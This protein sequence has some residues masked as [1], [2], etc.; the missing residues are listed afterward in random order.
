MGKFSNQPNWYDWN[1]TGETI[2]EEELNA[3]FDRLGINK[4]IPLKSND[5]PQTMASKYGCDCVCVKN[6]PHCQV[7]YFVEQIKNHLKIKGKTYQTIKYKQRCFRVSANNMDATDSKKASDVYKIFINL[8]KRRFNIHFNNAFK[9]I[10]DRQK[11]YEFKRCIPAPINY[12]RVDVNMYTNVYKIDISSAYAYEFSKD[13]PTAE[14]MIEVPGFVKPTSDF[15]FAYYPK[16][17]KLEIYG[18]NIKS[19][20]IAAERTVLM[21]KSNYSLKPLLEE[22]YEKKELAKDKEERQSYKNL[23]N[24]TVGYLQRNNNPT[25]AYITAVVIARCDER[26][27]RIANEIEQ[28]GINDVILINTD[29]I[30]WTGEDMPDYYTSEKKLGNFM[31]EYANADAYVR[32]SKCYQLRDKQTKEVH[33]IYAG[34]PKEYSEQLKFGD[35]ITKDINYD[36]YQWNEG[37]VRFTRKTLDEFYRER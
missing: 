4:I 17:G 31:L 32:G 25:H 37:K 30:A 5:M 26:V 12:G 11:A 24:Y 27:S 3:E 16:E 36:V 2:S 28:K 33:T 6:F 14:G 22:I 21:K 10:N 9:P 20:L 13:L 7:F 35:I 15:P 8:F 19:K 18:E 1:M 23:L 29:A 34:M